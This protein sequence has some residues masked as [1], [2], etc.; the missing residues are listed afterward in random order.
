MR[1][2][3]LLGRLPRMDD[4][5]TRINPERLHPTPGYHHITVLEAG[6][7]GPAF[8]PAST[9]LGVTRLGFPGRLVEVDLTAPLA[10]RS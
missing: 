8:S 7:P 1:P 10:D 4:M 9:L 5:I 3:R 2:G 6:R